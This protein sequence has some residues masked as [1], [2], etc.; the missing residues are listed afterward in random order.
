MYLA[1]YHLPNGQVAPFHQDF[2]G[3]QQLHSLQICRFEYLSHPSQ[4]ERR[5]S[6]SVIDAEFSGKFGLTDTS[7]S[8]AIII[9]LGKV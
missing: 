9:S 4:I 3:I 8:S 1:N 7:I 6:L 5:V 2:S